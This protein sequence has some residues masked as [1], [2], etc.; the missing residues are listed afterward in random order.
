MVV[1]GDSVNDPRARCDFF[2]V[3]EECEKTIVSEI[4]LY[5][6]TG[7]S[8]SQSAGGPR[9]LIRGQADP[10]TGQGKL[11]REKLIPA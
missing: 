10:L 1:A 7:Q 5:H 4:L 9:Q 11:K 2:F 8:V 3:S 6:S